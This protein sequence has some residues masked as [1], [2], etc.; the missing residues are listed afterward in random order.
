[1]DSIL[2]E[3][4]VSMPNA[5][6][7]SS[8]SPYNL[9]LKTGFLIVI[10]ICACCL[11]SMG[12]NFKIDKLFES[13]TSMFACC[14]LIIFMFY[15]MYEFFKSDTCED[16]NKSGWDRFKTSASRGRSYF[17]DQGTKAI[18]S[19]GNNLNSASQR[20]TNPTANNM[21]NQ[22]NTWGQKFLPQQYQNPIMMTPPNIVP[23]Q[24]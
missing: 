10:L 8:S 20:I 24:F 7:P 18:T 15:V 16:L 11:L 3:S 17:G 4:S 21:S 22:I 12:Y 1:M 2:N 5:L 9:N 14:I 13:G 19:M 23:N 6:T